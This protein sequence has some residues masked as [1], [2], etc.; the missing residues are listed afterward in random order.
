MIESIKYI[1][2]ELFL[3]L[4]S[5]SYLML[6]AFSNG[7]T[8]IVYSNN[9]TALSLIVAALILVY[10][11]QTNSDPVMGGYYSSN[12]FTIF[13]KGLILILSALILPFGIV[14]TTFPFA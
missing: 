14:I 4:Y 11:Q 6:A 7:K 5:L 3:V 12:E 9:I 10:G 8:L 2:P 13:F 1:I